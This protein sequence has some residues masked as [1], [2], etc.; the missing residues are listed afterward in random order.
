MPGV[1]TVVLDLGR[2]LVRWEPERAWAHLDPTD[3]ETFHADVD[4]LAWNRTLDAGVPCAEA[5]AALPPQHAAVGQAYVD[6]F[7]DALPGPVPGTRAVVEELDAAGLHLI[8]LTNWSA[9]LFERA[10]ELLEDVVGLSTF[11]GVVVSGREGLTKPDPA[12]FRRLL[13]RFDLDPAAT[14]FVDDS[15]ANVEAAAALGLRAV[16]FTTAEALRDALAD[17]GLPV[18]RPAR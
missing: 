5:V 18:R 10:G 16:G 8:A 1:T 15:P 14:A 7:L 3:V 2:V 13:D 4:F 9:E 11:D 6:R 12:L 17:L